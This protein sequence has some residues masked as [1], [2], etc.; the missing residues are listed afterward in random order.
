MFGAHNLQREFVP[1]VIEKTEE[2]KKKIYEKL[3][4]SF[5]FKNLEEK[6]QEIVVNAMEEKTFK[7]DEEVIKQG[8][9]GDVLYLVYSGTL[10][11]FKKEKDK[12]EDTFLVTY[13]S[14]Q[15]FGE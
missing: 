2:Q 11:C 6:E 10:N 7:K 13:K 8:D 15:A 5:M 12:E 9:D 3:N 14:G 4:E 1:K